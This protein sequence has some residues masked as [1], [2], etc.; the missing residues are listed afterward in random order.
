MANIYRERE[1]C[2]HAE[3]AEMISSI[4]GAETWGN[5]IGGWPHA[6]GFS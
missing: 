2:M 3:V 5:E 6:D 1:I 4:L